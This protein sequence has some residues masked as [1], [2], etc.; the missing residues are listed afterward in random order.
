MAKS[1][2][3]YIQQNDFEGAKER[4]EN[5]NKQWKQHWFDTCATIAKKAKEWLEIYIL[6]PIKL[7]ITKIYKTTKDYV[8]NSYVYLIKMFD[9]KDNYIFLKAGKADNPKERF[10]T[11]S[12]NFYKRDNIQI[13]KVIPL[14]VWGMPN[15]HLAQAFEQIVH[16]YLSSLFQNIP[17]DRYAPVE[18]TEE[19]FNEIE[20]K[21][22]LMTNFF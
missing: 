1:S 10:S 20:R 4:F 7:T 19:I 2:T 22:E 16:S 13:T 11:L 14:R 9:D 18:I 15:N 6:D 17:N 8:S 21:Y 3:I 12:K 5:A